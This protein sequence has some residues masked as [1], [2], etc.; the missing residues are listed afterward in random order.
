[1]HKAMVLFKDATSNFQIKVLILIPG[2]ITFWKWRVTSSDL[3][4]SNLSHAPVFII[5]RTSKWVLQRIGKADQTIT[6]SIGI[7]FFSFFKIVA[8]SSCHSDSV[9]KRGG[10]NF[11][12]L[13][14]QA[15]ISLPFDDFDKLNLV[16]LIWLLIKLILLIWNYLFAPYVIAIITKCTSNHIHVKICD[17]HIGR[18]RV[19]LPLK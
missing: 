18:D 15:H 7:F 14:S 19:C 10:K 3:I 6:G 1:M 13:I 17:T 2:C 5:L 16:C 9:Q 11:K 4:R 8:C 12:W